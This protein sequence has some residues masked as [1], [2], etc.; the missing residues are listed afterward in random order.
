MCPHRSN[1]PKNTEKRNFFFQN[2]TYLHPLLSKTIKDPI[3]DKFKLFTNQS[4]I[5]NSNYPEI[6]RSNYPENTEKRKKF[7]SKST[8]FAISNPQL[9]TKSPSLHLIY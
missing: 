6:I 7:F 1:F 3:F 9:P 2:F 8:K 5:K 4:E